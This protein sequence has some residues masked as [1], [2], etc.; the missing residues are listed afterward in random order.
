MSPVDSIIKRKIKVIDMD[1]PKLLI[2]AIVG[3]LY[4]WVIVGTFPQRIKIVEEQKLNDHFENLER[5][6]FIAKKNYTTMQ[7]NPN[8]TP[9]AVTDK[10]EEYALTLWEK[11]S[12]HPAKDLLKEV[13][14]ERLGRLKKDVYDT[15]WVNSM[16][17][18][19]GVYRD[20]NDWDNTKKAHNAILTYDNQMSTLDPK[21][22]WTIARDYNNLGLILYMEACGKEKDEQRSQIMRQATKEL[23]KA[24]TLWRE[25]KGA[26]SVS[27]A[28]T[29]WNLYLV[30]RDL[31]MKKEAAQTKL[32]A[33][34]M[35]K[36]AGHKAYSPVY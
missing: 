9:E 3:I 13:A 29:L 21:Y 6:I 1:G 22:K 25:T 33:Q 30:E 24:L 16:L 4:I 8:A 20:L 11:R 14:D 34:A 26:D 15:K 28:N 17:N 10:K 5:R 36:K 7:A 12:F 2:L 18:L 19:A 27:E 23:D 32:K 31:G 35:D